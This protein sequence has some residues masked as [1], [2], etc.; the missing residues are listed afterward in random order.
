M[1]ASQELSPVQPF[2]GQEDQAYAVN[3][4]YTPQNFKDAVR[5]IIEL[6]LPTIDVYQGHAKHEQLA[7]E[8]AEQTFA[9]GE[10]LLPA[11]EL[12]FATENSPA[13]LQ[14]LQH[15]RALAMWRAERATINRAGTSQQHIGRSLVLTTISNAPGQYT[16]QRHNVTTGRSLG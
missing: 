11:I 5:Y 9:V 16:S 15:N 8:L 1:T 3:T 4:A 13:A 10:P 12:H 7:R 6:G 2:D 14:D